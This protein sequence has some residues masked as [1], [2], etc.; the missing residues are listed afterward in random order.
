MILFAYRVGL[1]HTK[2]PQTTAQIKAIAA[3]I[4]PKTMH[5]FSSDHALSRLSRFLS[6]AIPARTA[7]TLSASSASQT[8]CSRLRSFTVFCSDGVK[9]SK[10]KSKPTEN[11]A[12]LWTWSGRD[13]PSISSPQLL[14]KARMAT[15]FM[16]SNI[17]ISLEPQMV[18]RA[19][20][21]CVFRRG[22]R[23]PIRRVWPGRFCRCW[24]QWF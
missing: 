1:S 24:A 19:G 16:R 21:A 8:H 23:T 12:P 4:T 9:S 5:H 22:W 13:C 15:S 20:R 3:N 2:T 18:L 6:S 17:S 10:G 11:T 14:R 7:L